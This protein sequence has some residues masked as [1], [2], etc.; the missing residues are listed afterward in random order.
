MV[1]FLNF[2]FV[3][4]LLWY[5]ACVAETLNLLYRDYTNGLDEYVGRLQR[6]LMVWNRLTQLLAVLSHGTIYGSI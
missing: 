3:N 2:E 4:E 1:P 5:V 6:R